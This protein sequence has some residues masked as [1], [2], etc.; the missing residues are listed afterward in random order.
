MKSKI[1]INSESLVS[2]VLEDVEVK[3]SCDSQIE[4]AISLLDVLEQ[5][6]LCLSESEFNVG[7]IAWEGYLQTI[8]E[9]KRKLYNVLDAESFQGSSAGFSEQNLVENGFEA[10][11]KSSE[12]L[13]AE[14][15]AS[16][17]KRIQ[18]L[19]S[20]RSAPSRS[21][22]VRELGRGANNIGIER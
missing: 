5:F 17:V 15:N 14:G 2:R 11:F 16:I 21:G 12:D 1:V 3:S 22:Q 19:P 8:T 18:K 6:S 10:N 9:V 20:P 7:E 4:E 13:I